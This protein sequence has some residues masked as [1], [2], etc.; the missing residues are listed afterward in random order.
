MGDLSI[1]N[2]AHT[3][4]IPDYF[5]LEVSDNRTNTLRDG[6]DDL[7]ILSDDEDLSFL[8][9]NK[10]N[11]RVYPHRNCVNFRDRSRC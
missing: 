2:S 7:D 8:Y 1:N 9:G 6:I 4:F 10:T 11:R 5:V 3:S